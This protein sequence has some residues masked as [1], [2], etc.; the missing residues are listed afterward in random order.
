MAE[1]ETIEAEYTN[2]KKW[3]ESQIEDLS[4]IK[5]KMKAFKK[6]MASLRDDIN[7]IKDIPNGYFGFLNQLLKNF[8]KNITENIFQFDD[9]IITPLDNFLFSF[10]FATSKN[11]NILQDIKK[12]YS[13]KN[14][15]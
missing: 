10:K 3:V 13:M 8:V 2:L 12:I 15:N 4:L 14:K 7:K 6:N 5:E 11:L 1:Y 9:L